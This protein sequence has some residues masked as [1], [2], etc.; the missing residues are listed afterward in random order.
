MAAY[1]SLFCAV[2]CLLSGSAAGCGALSFSLALVWLALAGG[3]VPPV[4]LP[5]GLREAVRLSPV[6]WLMELT[7]WPM[8]Y[9][10]VP[11]SW[12]GL[13]LSSAGMAGL[14]LI[15]YR[16]RTGWQEVSP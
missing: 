16:R 8:G 4:L 1:C 12:A 6:T 10:P 14:S 3:I 7:A 13:L 2:C 15:L 11:A 5:A 9:P